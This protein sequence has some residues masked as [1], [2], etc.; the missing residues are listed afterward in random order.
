MVIEKQTSSETELVEGLS[1]LLLH[2]L[3]THDPT[4]KP[5]RG[6]KWVNKYVIAVVDELIMGMRFSELDSDSIQ[7]RKS[8]VQ[9]KMGQVKINNSTQ[10][11]FHYF[12]S[13]KINLVETVQLGFTG[14]NSRVK[15]VERYKD[16]LLDLIALKIGHQVVRISP[17]LIE[18][19]IAAA[20][21]LIPVSRQSLCDYIERSREQ[22]LTST[23]NYKNAILD[24][25]ARASDLL[26]LIV[27]D[28]TGE[29]LPEAYQVADTGREYGRGFSLQCQPKM[30]RH[31]ALGHCHQYDFQAHS[32]AVMTSLARMIARNSGVDI[33]TS[34]IEDYVRYRSRIRTQISTETGIPVEK[35]KGIFTSLGFGA[36]VSAS[37]Y[38]AIR[39]QVTE[40]QFELLINNRTFGYIVEELK[41]VQ[42][43]IANQFPSDGFE[44]AL[45]HNYTPLDA[46][47]RKRNRSQKLA[48]IYQNLETYTRVTFQNIVRERTGQEPL[49][50]VHDGVYYAEPI[51]AEVLVDAQVLL[52]D[53]F[54]LVRIEH[55]PI[56][57]I[58]TNTGYANRH[59]ELD[60][61]QLDHQ[62][63]MREQERIARGYQPVAVACDSAEAP[64]VG[65]APEDQAAARLIDQIKW[66]A[67]ATSCAA[68]LE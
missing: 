66:S 30:V 41:A 52:R 14:F 57:P 31:A 6:I 16:M 60:Q 7:F 59:A 49:L 67:Y 25:I 10:W 32:F 22:A 38:T 3:L 29:Y 24:G 62:Q 13:A 23:G 43:L 40:E 56:W 12:T 44:G 17:E 54:E 1:E 11:L 37:P 46:E 9:Q 50:T 5:A 19:T 45:G 20:N 34:A 35:I 33:Q 63:R 39:G 2:R 36:R 4:I 42:E 15:I 21:R 27:T 28:D 8:Q 48:W 55:T 47:G 61:E 65:T 51:P 68:E 26:Q 58:T 53:E 18:E 64:V